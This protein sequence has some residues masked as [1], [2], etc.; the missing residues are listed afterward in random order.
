M[1][2]KVIKR[3]EN[4]SGQRLTLEEIKASNIQNSGQILIFLGA[5]SASTI[6]I[7]FFG[8]MTYETYILSCK[9]WISLIFKAL[10]VLSGLAQYHSAQKLAPEETMIYKNGIPLFYTSFLFF[11]CPEQLSWDWIEAK[12]K[13]KDKSNDF[14]KVTKKRE[15]TKYEPASLKLYNE[16]GQIV[17]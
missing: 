13:N 10:V 2:E 11:L 7:A 6:K 3:V 8:K 12:L 5:F 16:T 4:C 14:V 9:F 1:D 17:W 15:I